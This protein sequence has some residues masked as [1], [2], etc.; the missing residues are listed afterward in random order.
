MSGGDLD[1]DVY[2]AIWDEEILKHIKEIKEPMTISEDWEQ[3]YVVDSKSES[4]DFSVAICEYFKN[5]SLG[6]ISNLHLRLALEHG[7]DNPCT[8]DAARACSI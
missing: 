2:M 5:D 4:F 7:L 6:Q 1:G 8:M 3:K